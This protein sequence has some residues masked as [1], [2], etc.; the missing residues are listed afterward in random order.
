MTWKNPH[1]EFGRGHWKLLNDV[2]LGVEEREQLG[3]PEAAA[4]DEWVGERLAAEVEA[5]GGGGVGEV[6]PVGA[7]GGEAVGVGGQQ[8]GVV[9]MEGK[10]GW[11]LFISR[12]LWPAVGS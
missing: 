10:V 6:G 3:V 5:A 1:L 2:S 12:T 7:L 9:C 8:G 4:S 11:Q